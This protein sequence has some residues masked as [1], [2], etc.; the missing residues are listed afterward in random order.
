MCGRYL[1]TLGYEEVFDL[2]FN[3]FNIEATQMRLDDYKPRYNIAPSQKVVAIIHDGKGYR[4][5]YLKW[6]FLPSWAKDE[7]IAYK[8][9]NARS[10]TVD[11][12]PAY[13]HAF[14]HQR[15]LLLADGF[16][17][18]QKTNEGKIPQLIRLKDNLP[19]TM[20]GLYSIYKRPDGQ[21][22]STCTIMTTSPNKLMEPIHNRMPVILPENSKKLWLDPRINDTM[23]LKELLKPYNSSDM[24]HYPISSKVNS[25]K[26]DSKDLLEAI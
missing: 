16:Y 6:G 2:L 15:C 19:Y 17:E 9:I 11:E 24:Y 7:K 21:R 10:E 20:A 18:W 4:A 5:G 26:N 12:K 25:P 23:A 3:N 13:K 8:M 14:H 22:V 1:L